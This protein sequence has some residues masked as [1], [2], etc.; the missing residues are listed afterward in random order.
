MP[1]APMIPAHERE[2]V[3]RVTDAFAAQP[4]A[5]RQRWTR[6]LAHLGEARVYD[7]YLEFNELLKARLGPTLQ[8]H[9]QLQAVRCLRDAPV[10][11]S[12]T[13]LALIDPQDA[14][15][16]LVLDHRLGWMMRH[17][18][19]SVTAALQYFDRVREEARRL[20]SRPWEIAALLEKATALMAQGSYEQGVEVC[21]RVYNLSRRNGLV[22]YIPKALMFKGYALVKLG[23][24][25]AGE[26]SL[27]KAH[28]LATRNDLVAEQ[29][30][31]LHQLAQI[32]HY[33]FKFFGLAL[34]YYQ[35]ARA[36]FDTVPVWPSLLDRVDEDA[37]LAQRE[38]GEL[39]LAK[40]LGP[41]PI[42]KLRQEYLTSLVNGFVGIPGI[43]NRSQL[44]ERIG[45]TR[46]A[47]H[48]NINS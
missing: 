8:T 37:A 48:R 39:D 17:R 5:V 7:A 29:G 21:M 3:E 44:G 13:E 26:E 30:M 35:Q 1:S 46:Q 6:A 24:H 27:Q 9:V 47:I 45:L 19:M 18:L 41:I 42:N 2:H 12:K 25:H 14:Y 10:E 22:E 4:E 15:Q 36:V 43:D 20:G 32:Y 11:R 28:E 16:T 38:L 33:D 34:E 31:A 40:I 23:K